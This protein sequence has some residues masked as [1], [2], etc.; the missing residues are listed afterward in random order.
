M[1]VNSGIANIAG[2]ATQPMKT[3]AD[4]RSIQL[5]QYYIL[6]KFTFCFLSSWLLEIEAGWAWQQWSHFEGLASF[7]QSILVTVLGVPLSQSFS[8]RAEILRACH[9]P[10]WFQPHWTSQGI[11][12][13]L[14]APLCRPRLHEESRLQQI[15]NEGLILSWGL[16][17][18]CKIPG[19]LTGVLYVPNSFGPGSQLK[20]RRRIVWPKKTEGNTIH[21]KESL[22][23]KSCS[24]PVPSRMG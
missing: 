23:G 5:K 9:S 24:L 3:W 12:L 1:L 15:V 2:D 11:Q 8:D 21:Q 17:A 16:N 7:G 13:A 14:A 18:G 19:L 10:N 22:T 20:I 4:I 6:M